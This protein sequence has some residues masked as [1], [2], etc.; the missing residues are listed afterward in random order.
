MSPL[1]EGIA[2]IVGSLQA[3][4]EGSPNQARDSTDDSRKHGEPQGIA[5]ALR[6]IEQEIW[7]TFHS[8]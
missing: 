6:R 3:E 7:L 2:Q 1:S 5:A 4:P 8:G